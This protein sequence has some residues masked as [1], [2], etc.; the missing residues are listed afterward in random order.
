MSEAE[1]QRELT[2]AI[3]GVPSDLQMGLVLERKELTPAEKMAKQ[4]QDKIRGIPQ[5]KFAAEMLANMYDMIADMYDVYYHN[6]LSLGKVTNLGYAN[7]IGLLQI[8]GLKSLPSVIS[9]LRSQAK[10]IRNLP[11]TAI[12]GADFENKFKKFYR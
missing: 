7:I 12:S 5:Q 11:K 1:L 8:P 10:E 9:S 2:M 3:S 4:R 6:D